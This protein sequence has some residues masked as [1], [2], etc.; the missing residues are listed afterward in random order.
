VLLGAALAGLLWALA[1][2]AGGRTVTAASS[3]PFGVFLALA[4]WAGW[5]ALSIGWAA[6]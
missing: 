2:R 6:R 3:V 4:G 1:A 5:V